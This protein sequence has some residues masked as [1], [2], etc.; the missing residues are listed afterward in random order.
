MTTHKLDNLSSTAKLFNAGW[1]SLG[2]LLL[3]SACV[4]VRA[5]SSEEMALIDNPPQKVRQKQDLLTPLALDW[6]KEIETLYLAKGRSL[7]EKEL[8]IARSVGVQ[9][10]E[11]VRIVVLADFPSPGNKTLRT[12]TKNYGMGIS[13]EGSRTIGYIIMLKARLKDERWILAHELTYIAKQEKMGRKAFVRR[14]IAERELMGNRR[15]P[16]ALDANEVALDF[17]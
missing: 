15:A 3:I 4:S 16:M 1:L 2:C 7:T 11:R 8:T 9:H 17:K 12:E 13:A 5:P 10:P 14:F 6:F